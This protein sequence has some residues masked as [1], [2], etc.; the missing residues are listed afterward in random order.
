MLSH[1][2]NTREVCVERWRR[3][4]HIGNSLDVPLSP[5]SPRS[6]RPSARASSLP[7]IECHLCISDLSAHCQ[8]R[9]RKNIL[10]CR[11]KRRFAI[12]GI[13]TAV[14]PVKPH[15]SPMSGFNMMEI[16]TR[17]NTSCVLCCNFD[18]RKRATNSLWAT[19]GEEFALVQAEILPRNL[20]SAVSLS[21]ARQG[22][23]L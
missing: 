16:V 20:K 9:T 14:W 3:S 15:L 23:R 18:L 22:L 12:D 1:F 6:N 13:P 17:H 8:E 21:S 4:A 7:S 2:R 11:S 5:G 19:C 10:G